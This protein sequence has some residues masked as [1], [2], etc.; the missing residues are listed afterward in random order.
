MN[1]DLGV[2]FHLG[3]AA[4]SFFQDAGL[5][6]ELVFITNM[7]IMAA[8]ATAE[9]G[10]GRFYP[11]WRRLQNLLHAPPRES[12][13]LFDNRRFDRFPSST[14]GTNAALPGPCSSEGSRARP[15]PP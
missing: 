14:K 13:L 12:A 4:K 15:S 5:D 1:F 7:L 3:G 11:L 6:L 2:Q 10:T 9:I 8:A